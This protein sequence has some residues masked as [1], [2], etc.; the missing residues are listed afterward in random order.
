MQSRLGLDGE[1]CSL[2]EILNGRNNPQ[3][4]RV[5]LTTLRQRDAVVN[6]ILNACLTGEAKTEVV[7]G[8]DLGLLGG[9]QVC[10]L[11]LSATSDNVLSPIARVPSVERP[12]DSIPPCAI[13]LCSCRAVFIM[14]SHSLGVVLHDVVV[15]L[16]GIPCFCL[17]EVFV[18]L[19]ALCVV[20][21]VITVCSQFRVVVAVALQAHPSLSEPRGNVSMLAGL[22]CEVV[23]EPLLLCLFA[24]DDVHAHSMACQMRVGNK[25]APE[26]ASSP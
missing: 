8:L 15:M 18:C 11:H 4:V 3:I 13:F 23:G 24:G 21:A 10:V 22:A 9:R 19:H 5:M 25:K 17:T 14:A 26:G 12:A 6:V 20:V 16:A 2:P 7:Q 1:L